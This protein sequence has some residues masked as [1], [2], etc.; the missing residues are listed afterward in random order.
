MK[1]CKQKYLAECLHR[2]TI[3]SGQ[4]SKRFDFFLGEFN[5][6]LFCP[7]LAY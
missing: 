6:V 5:A 1:P 2:L 3:S 7:L 4:I